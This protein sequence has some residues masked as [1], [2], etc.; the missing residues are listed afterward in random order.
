[1]AVSLTVPEFEHLVE[2]AMDRL[3]Q[4]VAEQMANVYVAVAWVPAA[5]QRAAS[6]LEPGAMLLG[7]YEGV[8]LTRRT[9]GYHLS[10]PD[11]I[12]LFQRSLQLLAQD[13]THLAALIQ[14]TIVHEIGHHFG[15]SEE[16]LARLDGQV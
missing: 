12:T 9:R 2:Q 3:P 8:P 11:R 6:R 16:D 13:E 14:Q 5:E 7:L 1:M 15:L 10:S 4:W